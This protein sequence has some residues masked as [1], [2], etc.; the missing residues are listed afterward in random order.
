MESC[1]VPGSGCVGSA[2]VIHGVARAMTPCRHAQFTRRNNLRI[3]FV[4]RP[5]ASTYGSTSMDCRH[6]L[7]GWVDSLAGLHHHASA[8][9]GREAG[10]GPGITGTVAR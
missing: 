5:A 10:N 1:V 6:A 4:N 9:A 2:A 3:W 7:R 8:A